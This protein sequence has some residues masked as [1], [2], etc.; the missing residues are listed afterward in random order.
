MAEIG[1]LKRFVRNGSTVVIKP[2][3]AFDRTP[4]VGAN[5]PPEIIEAVVKIYERAGAKRIIVAKRSGLPEVTFKM[6]SMEEATRKAGGEVLAL[7]DRKIFKQ[8]S[9]PKGKVLRENEV[10]EVILNADCYIN[11]P[12]AK[13]MPATGVTLG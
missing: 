5:P 9:I 3:A 1:G 8:V 2:N 12:L 6:S 10:A 11:I 7:S 13:V 4:D